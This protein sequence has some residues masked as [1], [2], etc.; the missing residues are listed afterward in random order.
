MEDT[1]ETTPS[2][3][4]NSTPFQLLP[5]LSPEQYAVLKADIEKRG[6]L[7]PVEVDQDGNLLDGHHRLKIAAE[8]GIEAPAITRTMESVEERTAY[9][10]SLNLKRRHLTPDQW[11]EMFRT[12]CEV[13]GV[14]TGKGARNDKTSATVAEVAVKEFGVPARTARH[15]MAKKAP[16]KKTVTTAKKKPVSTKSNLYRGYDALGF[17]QAQ[18]R[19]STAE[20]FVADLPK[21][22]RGRF[23]KELPDVITWLTE[24]LAQLEKAR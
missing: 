8:L 18:C 5:G 22:G 20:K 9:I 17:F 14:K 23:T 1:V 3:R 13:K 6:V 2:A 12:Y 7:V 11:G 10:I 21:D 16:P 24:V 19:I 15:R 4:P